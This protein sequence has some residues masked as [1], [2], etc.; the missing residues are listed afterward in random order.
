MRT[1]IIYILKQKIILLWKYFCFFTYD[2]V[3]NKY[4]NIYWEQLL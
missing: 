3:K 4:L 1:Y 2:S